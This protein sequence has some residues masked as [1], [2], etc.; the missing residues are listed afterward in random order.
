MKHTLK[1]IHDIKRMLTSLEKT[2]EG[3][4][5]KVK[6]KKY[7]VQN[8]ILYLT[9]EYNKI[10]GHIKDGMI[11]IK[12]ESIKN[13]TFRKIKSFKP[14]KPRTLSNKI[15]MNKTNKN[16]SVMNEEPTESPEP[17]EESPEPVMNEEPPETVINED[18]VMNEETPEPVMTNSDYESE[19]TTPSNNTIMDS[20][21]SDD[22]N[23]S[24]EESSVKPTNSPPM[25]NREKYLS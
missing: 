8:N 20:N 19:T 23:E 22:E 11:R 17:I 1:R 14:I 10:A 7:Y 6:N 9:P 16:T 12:G 5:I 3:T 25:E 18:S 2:I 4:F 21:T 13:S 15:K 24:P